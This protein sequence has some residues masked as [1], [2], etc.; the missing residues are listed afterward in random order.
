MF[1]APR[2]LQA[3]WFWGFSGPETQRVFNPLGDAYPKQVLQ[4][5][6]KL[7]VM[8]AVQGPHSPKVSGQARRLWFHP[9]RK[10]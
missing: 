5:C 7:S 4:S 9:I 2:P 1:F 8:A 3:G 10:W 6:L